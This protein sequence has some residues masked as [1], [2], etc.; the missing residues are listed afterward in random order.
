MRQPAESCRVDCARSAHR[1]AAFRRKAL[2]VAVVACMGSLG[3]LPGWAGP[4]GGIVIRGDASISQTPGVTTID[5]RS[6]RT[7]IN[8]N[9]F[10]VDRGELAQ[11]KQPGKDSIA[12]NRVVGADRSNIQGNIKAN[13]NVWLV[14]RNGVLIGPDAK[15][16]V[17]GFMATTADIDDDHFMAGRNEF[18]KPSPNK[19][20]TVVNQ[21]TITIGEKG[22]AALV[23]PHAR[24]DGVI[25]GK[26]GT[27]VIAGTPTHTVDFYGDGLIQF[28]ATSEVTEKA[29]PER[30]LAE[31]NGTI[32]VNGGT[33]LVTANAAAKIVDDVINVS[34]VVEARS[35]KDQGGRIVL[36]G[37]D[38][39]IVRV[40]GRLDASG[41]ER[42]AKGGKIKVSGERITTSGE[43]RAKGSEARGGEIE[44]K[45]KKGVALGAPVDASGTSGG[46]IRI[47]AGGLSLAEP[48][49][50]R[51]STGPGGEVTLRTDTTSVETTTAV[52]D[53]SGTEGG[54]ISHIA[55]QQITTS[56]TYRA[57]GTAGK[58]GQ[59][60]LTAPATKLLSTKLDAS[61]QTGGGQ[62]RLGGEFQGGKDLEVDELPNAQ[63]LVTT[64]ATSIKAD[65]LGPEGDG[66]RVI[67]WS[68]Q[69]SVFLGSISAL[70]G[71]DAGAGG[72]IE[73][74]SGDSLT[75]AG[76]AVSGIGERK[77]TVLLDPKNITISVSSG[78]ITDATFE[79]N[80]DLDYTI[81]PA[82]LA[83]LLGSAQDVVLQANNDITVLDPVTVSAGGAGGDLTLE[84]GRSVL[85]NAD[86]FTDGGDLNVFANQTLAAGALDFYRDPGA[87]VIAMADGTTLDAG[88]GT[89]RLT[90]QTDPTKADNTTGDITLG[91]LSAS[92][93]QITNFGIGNVRQNAGSGISAG[94]LL[95]TGEGSFLLDQSNDVDT[96]AAATGIS[97]TLDFWDTDGLS[98]G[99]VA[100]TSGIET[101]SLWIEAHGVLAVDAPIAANYVALNAGNNAATGVA[102]DVVLHADITT[103]GTIRLAADNDVVLAGGAI[104]SSCCVDLYADWDLD[105]QGQIDNLGASTIT[106]SSLYLEAG[107]GIGIS[108]PIATLAADGGEGGPEIWLTATTATGPIRVDNMGAVGAETATMYLDGGEGGAFFTD[109]S[110]EVSNRV[111]SIAVLTPVEGADVTLT[112]ND[113]EISDSVTATSGLLTLST[114]NPLAFVDVPASIAGQAEIDWSELDWLSAGQA[115]FEGAGIHFEA[116][117]NFRSFD[118]VI[119][120]SIGRSADATIDVTQ[121]PGAEIDA[122]ALGIEVG[123]LAVE[124]AAGDV[125]LTE[126]NF[127]DRLAVGRAFDVGPGV[128]VLAFTN[129]WDLNIGVVNPI[130]ILADNVYLSVDG[131]ITVD[132]PITA[133]NGVELVARQ[134][135]GGEGMSPGDVL[136]NAAVTAGGDILMQADDFFGNAGA[137]AITSV[138]GRV[139]VVAGVGALAVGDLSGTASV[140]AAILSQ[141]SSGDSFEF[142]SVSIRA[143]DSFDST[144]PVA[145]SNGIVSVNVGVDLADPGSFDN[146][147]LLPDAL[148]VGA[149]LSAPNAEVVLALAGELELS[150][151]VRFLDTPGLTVFARDLTVQAEADLRAT[152]VDR[153]SLFALGGDVSQSGTAPIAVD[154]L[155]IF[156]VTQTPSSAV[157]LTANNRVNKLAVGRLRDSQGESV[158]TFSDVSF[159]NSTDL[160]IGQIDGLLAPTLSSAIGATAGRIQVTVQ[161]ALTLEAPVVSSAAGTS[162]VLVA[163]RFINTLGDSALDPG[164]G[165]YLVYSDDPRTDARNISVDQFNKLYAF[166]FDPTDPEG[167]SRSLPADGNYFLYA[168]APTLSIV[169][170]DASREYGDPNPQFTYTFSGLIDGDTLVDALSAMPLLTTTAVLASN[171]GT[172]SI[173]VGPG[174][175][176]SP[177]N[178]AVAPM[179]GDLLVTPAPLTAVVNDANREYGDP[180]PVFSAAFA[181]FKLG[182]D[183][184]VLGSLAFATD[185]ALASPVAGSPYAITLSGFD[186]TNY[187]LAGVTEGA[188]TITPAPLT[189]LVNNASRE[190]GDPNPAFSAT[191]AGFKLAQDASV[192]GSLAFATDAALAS[193]VAGSPYA[194]TLSGFDNTNY[195]LTG[196]TDGALTITPAPLT[197]LVNDATRQ[198]GD[199]NPVFSASFGGFKLGQD[200]S[201]LGAIVFETTAQIG[202]PVAGS[203]YGITLT[204][205]D[206]SNYA[207]VQVINGALTVVPAPLT[208]QAND[209]M[210]NSGQPNPA[211]SASYSG[212]KLGEGPSV[213]SGLQ[214]FTEANRLSRAGLY[215]IVPFGATAANYALN[216]L[217]GLLAVR[218]GSL[219]DLGL[220]GNALKP[221]V[222]LADLFS[223]AFPLGAALALKLSEAEVPVVATSPVAYAELGDDLLF[224]D[225]GNP[226]LWGPPPSFGPTEEMLQAEKEREEESSEP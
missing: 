166:P 15:V 199:P 143:T 150:R 225:D 107:D 220:A 211:F 104:N 208:I 91:N 122:R 221:E 47:E 187:V 48:V 14:N 134:V 140:N 146:Y 206:N 182:Q 196:V 9:G 103:G 53:V 116:P 155:G 62:V 66:G 198:Y 70:P 97:S 60:D 18:S 129:T 22:L 42:G 149:A 217:N 200:T 121:A 34:G 167:L 92:E 24:N 50:A 152:G 96:L 39:G 137:G 183:A 11:F 64:D 16:D 87:A 165:R 170:N 191:F 120:R 123:N 40:A 118:S 79:I 108:A 153:A 35:F 160:T 6:G 21:G 115:V 88:G 195:V 43:L 57:V 30:A 189:A 19:K 58:G 81:S 218:V 63:T 110:I 197:A 119:L 174:G 179:D 7:V 223:D 184:S 145:S 157:N 177:L 193:P 159:A 148:S 205:F 80:P 26:L 75:F 111:G 113:F 27:V 176:S 5:Q 109:D 214:F 128:G 65:A 124:G 69:Q 162:T 226:L 94:G 169:A 158:L 12:L 54:R 188:L 135:D 23:A 89:I 52:V 55:G 13:G 74:S 99:S 117:T 105:G 3:P 71:S 31:N 144:A 85:F 130:G 126:A 84:A 25:Q 181:G 86:I 83:G 156:S 204:G 68:D 133:T 46:S 28:E 194:I 192:L 4:N 210:R 219:A 173:E 100:G 138:G 37:G 212:F 161:G 51:G 141:M 45:G 136:V 209:A 102:G 73:V 172:Y 82:A 32:K 178:Y 44:V 202:S 127:V 2:W 168:F 49:L 112:A 59:I 98:V 10:S 38:T 76:T 186:N 180:N 106:T 215:D 20:A 1:T 201:V 125:V 216:Y 90:M 222:P 78:S 213:V 36:D 163:N 93:V 29:E 190:Y 41:A 171:V 224:A 56:G 33:V 114:P 151:Y 142:P 95:L 203:P 185:A 164:D 132:E 147:D 154:E 175:L 67:L 61:G 101:G 72:F 131:T 207:L 8:W 139:E 17:H 77:G